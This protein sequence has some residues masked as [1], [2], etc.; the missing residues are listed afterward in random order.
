MTAIRQETARSRFLLPVANGLNSLFPQVFSRTH[1]FVRA[2]ANSQ[3]SVEASF[4]RPL[5][6]S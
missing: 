4:R 1:D 5:N 2:G 6:G 3:K